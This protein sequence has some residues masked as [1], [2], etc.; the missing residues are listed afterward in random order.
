[1]GEDRAAPGR[2]QAAGRGA[3]GPAGDRGWDPVGPAAEGAVAGR[4]GEVR[5]AD[6]LLAVV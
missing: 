3:G 2:G 1:M 6:D 4:A 5:D